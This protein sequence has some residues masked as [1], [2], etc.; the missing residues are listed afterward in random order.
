MSLASS[1]LMSAIN[2]IRTGEVFVEPSSLQ[3]DRVIWDEVQNS[4]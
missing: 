4:S 1:A 3:T 2:F